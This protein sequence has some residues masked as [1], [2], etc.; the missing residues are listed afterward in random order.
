MGDYKELLDT[1]D[2][3][4]SNLQQKGRETR[5]GRLGGGEGAV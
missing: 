4:V 5:E 3:V 1:Y 2:A